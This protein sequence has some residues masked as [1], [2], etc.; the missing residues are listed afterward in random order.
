MLQRFKRLKA[1][2]DFVIQCDCRNE[3]VQIL[4]QTSH[5]A[6]YKV[7]LLNIY[8]YNFNSEQILFYEIYIRSN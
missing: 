7:S 6:K 1:F 4:Y 2:S 5:L 3:C 8:S